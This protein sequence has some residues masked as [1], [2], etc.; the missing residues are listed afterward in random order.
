[1][2][3]FEKTIYSYKKENLYSYPNEI[4]FENKNNNIIPFFN[5][6][7][8]SIFSYNN[9]NEDEIF[10]KLFNYSYII[11][12]RFNIIQVEYSILFFN[13][14]QSL[15][16]PSDLCLLYDL[17]IICRINKIGTYMNIDSL[18]SIYLNKYF[19]CIEFIN[20]NEK[21]YFGILI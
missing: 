13:Q 6:F 9:N 12:F 2:T 1:M 11:S 19:H 14:N 15:I 10:Y 16:S 5:N 8:L 21:A 20:I 3:K 17:H 7:K 4:Y 18:A